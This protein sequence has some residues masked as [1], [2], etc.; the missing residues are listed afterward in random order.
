M[1]KPSSTFIPL[2]E[3]R[4]ERLPIFLM[5]QI[6]RRYRKMAT[7]SLKKMEAGISLDQWIL[8]KQI[9]ENNGASQVEIAQS[10]VKDAPTTTRIIDQ[11]TEK[12]LVAKQLDPEDRRKYMVFVTDKGKQLID[13]LLPQVRTYRM[14][15][16]KSFSKEEKADLISLLER[17][18][19]NLP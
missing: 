15:P 7:R 2:T 10:T 1:P 5:E 14:I 6:I 16:L 13:Q 18:N 3:D 9:S 4:I 17:M 8:L 11:L 12:N 19:Q